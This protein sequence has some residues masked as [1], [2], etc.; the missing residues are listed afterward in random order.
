VGVG[1][2]GILVLVA[3]GVG[4]TRTPKGTF[5]NLNHAM[6]ST[7]KAPA[8]PPPA[9]LRRITPPNAQQSSPIADSLVRSRAFT[10]WTIVMGIVLVAALV[11]AYA[12]SLGWIAAMLVLYGV[13][14]D[15]LPRA[16]PVGPPALGEPLRRRATGPTAP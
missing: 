1:T 6:D 14:G 8:P 2:L 9:W 3:F 13:T 10:L 11:A 7:A 15:W 5:A 12:G 16:E 4:L